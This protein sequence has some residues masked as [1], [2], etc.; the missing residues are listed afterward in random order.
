M[1]D[2]DD[3]GR[4]SGDLGRRV[5]FRRRQLGL[6]Y[7]EVGSRAGIAPG[8]VEYVEHRHAKVSADALLRLAQAL[9]TRV[10]VLLGAH[11]E[12]PAGAFSGSGVR[13]RLSQLDAAECIRLIS[14]GG[15]GRVVYVGA[16][17]PE[18]FPVNYVVIGGA[19]LFRTTPGGV[20][21]RL[22]GRR[23]GF[24]V[25][26]FDEPVVRGWS[27]LVRGVLTRV[28]DRALATRVR[29]T[30]RP[31]AGGSRDTC[32]RIDPDRISGRRVGPGEEHRR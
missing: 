25:D 16:D 26:R 5:A 27:V 9:E 3:N 22:T 15:V 19:V 13:Q 24:E 32:V 11:A 17:G 12:T 8:Y 18:A 14:P 28:T 20:V 21:A 23:V 4:M 1:T 29:E 6:S 31:W 2:L 10:D 30:V 7:E